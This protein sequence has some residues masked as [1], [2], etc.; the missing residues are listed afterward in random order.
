MSLIVVVVD[1]SLTAKST[2]FGLLDISPFVLPEIKWTPPH[3]LEQKNF[4]FRFFDFHF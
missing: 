2:K 1:P 4:F 3:F